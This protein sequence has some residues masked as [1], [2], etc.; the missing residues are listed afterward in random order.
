M[1]LISMCKLRLGMVYCN[2]N[3][4]NLEVYIW[5]SLFRYIHKLIL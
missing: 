3:V 4:H 2:I 1:G 5:G